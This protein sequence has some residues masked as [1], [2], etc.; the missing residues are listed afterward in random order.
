MVTRI[1]LPDICD[2]Q[3]LNAVVDERQGGVNREF[4]NGIHEQWRDRVQTYRDDGISLEAALPWAEASA[5]S[6]KF[7]TLYKSPR[8]GSTQGTIL[9][10]LR[11]HGYQFCP[12]CGEAGSP[13]TLD[14]FLPKEKYPH[15]AITVA[16]LTPM[17]SRCQGKKGDDVGDAETP[18]FF[19]HPYFDEF[20]SQQILELLIEPPYN[21]P[22]FALRVVED[23]GEDETEIAEKHVELLDLSSRFRK[24]FRNRYSQLMR[25][26]QDC[27]DEE[28]E[29]QAFLRITRRG[30]ARIGL[31]YWDHV[32]F[33][34]VLG[35]E[36]LLEFLEGGEL[37]EYV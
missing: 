30:H 15:F 14:H 8:D 25:Q 24:F 33:S 18:R 22:R 31:N 23:L 5:N 11:D 36:E 10:Q 28:V 21:T 34:S 13:N 12:S 35:N 32:F 7:L 27:R 3:L 37:P 2:V 19:I 16:N 20:A 26:A 1:P 6:T 17:C 9:R 4:F 29:F